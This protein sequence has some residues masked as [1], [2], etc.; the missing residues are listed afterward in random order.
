[1]LNSQNILGRS[2]SKYSWKSLLPTANQSNTGRFDGNSIEKGKMSPEVD[3]L[4]FYLI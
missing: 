2:R 1:M 4:L 3:S